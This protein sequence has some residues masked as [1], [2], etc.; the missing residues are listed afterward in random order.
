MRAH[1][2]DTGR[3]GSTG[4]QGGAASLPVVTVVAGG[5]GHVGADDRYPD[6]YATGALAAQLSPYTAGMDERRTELAPCL[7]DKVRGRGSCA[8]S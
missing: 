7:V 3:N 1:G 6:G 5:N 4:G 2:R 8:K